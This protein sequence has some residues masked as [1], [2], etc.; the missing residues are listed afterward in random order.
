MILR[1]KTLLRLWRT[2]LLA[3][4]GFAFIITLF[5]ILNPPAQGTPAKELLVELLSDQMLLYA[6][7][8][9]ATIMFAADTDSGL[10]GYTMMSPI[11]QW[12]YAIA[13]M[14]LIAIATLPASLIPLLTISGMHRV[15]IVLIC[16]HIFAI[17]VGAGLSSFIPWKSAAAFTAIALAAIS[18]S[19]YHSVQNGMLSSWVASFS[20]LA[21]LTGDYLSPTIYTLLVAV[22]IAVREELR[23]MRP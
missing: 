17:A 13:K 8:L 22:G 15:G 10:L 12:L 19:I 3:L 2:T 4:Y 18:T 16:I 1:I 23:Q 6:I 21:P 20:L 9:S 7:I 5:N 11:P 14:T